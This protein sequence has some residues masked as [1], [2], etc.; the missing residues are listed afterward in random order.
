MGSLGPQGLSTII[1][2]ILQKDE[3]DLRKV[4]GFVQASTDNHKSNL[5]LGV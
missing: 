4:M 2:S 1:I 5:T 3:L